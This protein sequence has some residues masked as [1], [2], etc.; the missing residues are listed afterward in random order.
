MNISDRKDYKDLM[1]SAFSYDEAGKPIQKFKIKHS[2]L[3]NPKI[4]NPDHYAYVYSKVTKMADFVATNYKLAEES[5]QLKEI[6][7]LTAHCA[8]T[9]AQAL[10]LDTKEILESKI[11]KNIEVT[12]EDINS[13]RYLNEM[14]SIL[15]Y[16]E[17]EEYS[18]LKN[19]DNDFSQGLNP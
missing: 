14:T 13:G 8:I 5:G 16:A 1:K 12:S 15:S 17:A 9:I 11:G 2:G 6:Q 19:R 3:E 4:L 10:Y 18:K 7:S